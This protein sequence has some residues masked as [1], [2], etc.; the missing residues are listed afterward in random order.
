MW[1]VGS[2]PC[3]THSITIMALSPWQHV[4]RMYIYNDNI[5]LVIIIL[6]KLYFSSISWYNNLS[7]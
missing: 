5:L 2:S 6:A 3:G 4:T 1:D 7:S